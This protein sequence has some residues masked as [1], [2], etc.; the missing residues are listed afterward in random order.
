MVAFGNGVVRKRKARARALAGGLDGKKSRNTCATAP[1][2]PVSLSRPR[3]L[4]SAPSGR[5]QPFAGASVPRTARW[6]R[7]SNARPSS[8]GTTSPKSAGCRY[9]ATRALG[10][11]ASGWPSQARQ[12]QRRGFALK[13]YAEDGNRD[14]VGSNAPVF[15]G[16]APQKFT[17]FRPTQKCGPRQP[18]SRPR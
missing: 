13:F 18:Q 15:F 5:C 8:C 9:S 3:I 7:L 2:M 12:H 1:L 6:Y 11:G 14:L 4:I 17:D 16:K 10:S